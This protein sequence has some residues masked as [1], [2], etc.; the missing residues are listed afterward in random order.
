[1]D[2]TAWGTLGDQGGAIGALVFVVIALIRGWI[3]PGYVMARD[4]EI[5]QERRDELR[6][7]VAY[8]RDAANRAGGLAEAGVDAATSARRPRRRVHGPSA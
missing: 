4:R 5:E 7:E 6:A 8:W 2:Q 3:V 1:V